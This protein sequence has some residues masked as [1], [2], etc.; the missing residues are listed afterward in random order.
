MLSF[1]LTISSLFRRGAKT[2]SALSETNP[3]TELS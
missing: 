1:F 3:T 2:E